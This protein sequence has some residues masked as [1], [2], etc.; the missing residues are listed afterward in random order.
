MAAEGHT[1]EE[2]R[3]AQVSLT[4]GMV[5]SCLRPRAAV[6]AA[7]QPDAFET[8]EIEAWYMDDSSEDQR[9]PHK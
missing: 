9:L 2:L 7:A 4:I 8:A 6:R 5:P 1:A 3:L